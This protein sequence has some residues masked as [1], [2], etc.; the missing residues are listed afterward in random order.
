[1]DKVAEILA[2]VATRAMDAYGL[3]ADRVFHDPIPAELPET[4]D[5]VAIRSELSGGRRETGGYDAMVLRID[6]AGE[7][8]DPGSGRL[9]ERMA[10]IGSLRSRLTPWG[11]G[12][13]P[14]VPGYEEPVMT[15]AM[16]APM[17]DAPGRLFV[18]MTYEGEV[19][20]AR[21]GA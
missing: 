16:T 13:H 1:M 6:V 21:G 12:I 10:L 8:A 5:Y 19:T 17:E 3:D 9:G 7:F 11:G 4:G 2:E 18:G 15:E 20:L 14:E